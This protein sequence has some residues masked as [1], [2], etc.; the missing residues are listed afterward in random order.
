MPCTTS[1][2]ALCQSSPVRRCL[3][4]YCKLCVDRHYQVNVCQCVHFLDVVASGHQAH[5][6][7]PSL[8]SCTLRICHVCIRACIV[9][10]HVTRRTQVALTLYA[11]TLIEPQVNMSGK[12]TSS[13]YPVNAQTRGLSHN[14]STGK[15]SV[16]LPLS[17]SM[18]SCAQ[19]SIPVM[20]HR[21]SFVILCRICTGRG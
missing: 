6:G 20:W 4:L 16:K 11:L 8:L 13:D 2:A 5:L 7:C 9:A 1:H 12:D 17:T 14:A 10:P 19:S 18:I 15:L 3:Y 21:D